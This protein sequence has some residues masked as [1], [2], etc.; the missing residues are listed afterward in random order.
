[1]SQCLLCYT[2]TVS[3]Q[4]LNEYLKHV[5]V[6]IGLHMICSFRITCKCLIT[7]YIYLTEIG[8]LSINNKTQPLSQYTNVFCLLR[9]ITRFWASGKRIHQFSTQLDKKKLDLVLKWHFEMLAWKMNNLKVQMSLFPKND[10]LLNQQDA[11]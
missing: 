6:V 10:I 2:Q 3:F 7:I 4:I 5:V 9:F 1:L 8:C 11:Y